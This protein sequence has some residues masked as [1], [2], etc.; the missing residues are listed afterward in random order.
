MT[1]ISCWIRVR[2]SSQFSYVIT[3]AA[4]RPQES[5]GDVPSA[6]RTRSV[7]RPRPLEELVLAAEDRR[8]GVVGEDVHDRLREE[9]GHCEDRHVVRLRERVDGDRVGDN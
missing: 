4:Q 1:T 7:P 9:A 3:G 2:S 5:L 6:T 8:D